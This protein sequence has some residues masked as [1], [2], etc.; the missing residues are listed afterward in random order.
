M[1]VDT[2]FQLFRSRAEARGL[3]E[4]DERSDSA[5]F[6]SRCITSWQASGAL[7]LIWNQKEATLALEITHG[8]PGGPNAWLDLFQATDRGE[9]H[10]PFQD[11]DIRFDEAVEYGLDLLT[12]RQSHSVK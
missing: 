11:G 8:P 12:P 9:K 4:L 2:A 1:T 5:P 10:F 7:R 6:G 3:S